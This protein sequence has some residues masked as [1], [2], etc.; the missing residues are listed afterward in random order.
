MAL[1]LITGVNGSGKSSAIRELKQRG[2][3]AYDTDERGP[4]TAKWHN[5]KTGYVHPKSSVKTEMR[6]PEFITEHSW[7]VPRQEVEALAKQEGTKTIFVCAVNE[8][9]IRDLFKLA[10]ALVI[11]DDTLR[12][13]LAN[14][15]TNNWG[16][17]RHELQ[18]SLEF[19]HRV[20]KTYKTNGYITIDATQS[21]D[22]VVDEILSHVN[23]H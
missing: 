11:D 22:K 9:D 21:L 13:R 18:Q 20:S 16:K 8:N 3:E 4:V 7:K 5:D 17:Q 1:Y 14:R 10:F 19:N 15:T 12:H 6:T 2:Y 23:E